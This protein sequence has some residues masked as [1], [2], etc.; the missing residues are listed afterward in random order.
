MFR[1]VKTYGY[2]DIGIK[3]S[4]VSNIEH[5]AECNVL[6]GNGKLPIF[7]APMTNVVNETNYQIFEDNKINAI[8]PRNISI[9]DRIFYLKKGMWVGFSANEFIEF[10]K[11]NDSLDYV[12]HMLIDA[13][14]GNMLYILNAC[15]KAKMKYGKKNIVLMYGN[16]VNALTYKKYCEYGIDYCRCSV[17]TGNGC[18]TSTQTGIHCGIASLIN[19]AYQYKKEVEHD[20]RYGVGNT[21]YI[22][23]TNIIADGG[24]RGYADVNKALA[25]G[26]DYVMIGSLF[27]QLLESSAE[28]YYLCNDNGSKAF[29]DV[30]NDPVDIEKNDNETFNLT[31]KC[32]DNS[33]NL[34][35]LIESCRMTNVKLVKLYYG[36]ASRRG[37]MDFY[38]KKKSTVEGTE[39][40]LPCTSTIESWSK[41]MQSYLASSMSYCGLNDV[42]KFSPENVETILI[43]ENVQQSIN[44]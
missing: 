26:A 24:I 31:W 9:E 17:G 11:N 21:D 18:I 5:R 40:W 27:C 13:A 8:L 32:E 33:T 35:G 6:K 22:C 43:S 36:M 44:K 39:K 12:P 14:N 42:N 23:V 15:K 2:N 20:M 25:L 10:V 34:G 1:E 4:V 37:Q 41:N 29:I 19:E 3:G 7:T 16:I 28:T 38:G 30:F